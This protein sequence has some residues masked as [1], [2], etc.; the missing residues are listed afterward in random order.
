MDH[1]V[2]SKYEFTVN[3]NVALARSTRRVRHERPGVS[4]FGR[5]A[6]AIL[7]GDPDMIAVQGWTVDVVSAV[8]KQFDAT[9]TLKAQIEVLRH[10]RER[11]ENLG[12]V[13][14]SI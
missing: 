11:L 8:G 2:E 14:I 3:K 4:C 1:T 6:D 5:D 13:T 7:D 9:W 10:G 12:K